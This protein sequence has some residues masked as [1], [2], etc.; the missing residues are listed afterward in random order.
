M[1]ILQWLATV[2]L[3]LAGL[4]LLIEP[5]HGQGTAKAAFVRT[6]FVVTHAG[7]AAKLDVVLIPGA[8]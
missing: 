3:V 2:V 6:R 1:K 8:G 5:V 7:T 4:V